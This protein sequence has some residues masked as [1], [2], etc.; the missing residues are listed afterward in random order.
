LIL[1]RDAPQLRFSSRKSIL[2]F[3]KWLVAERVGARV[4]MMTMQR[5]VT[6]S[7]VKFSRFLL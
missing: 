7:A 6:L 4:G 1:R 3:P 2:P 5:G